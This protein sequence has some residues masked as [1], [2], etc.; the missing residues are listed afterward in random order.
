[1]QAEHAHGL[2]H[3]TRSTRGAHGTIGRL[4]CVHAEHDWRCHES[5]AAAHRRLYPRDGYNRSPYRGL[6]VAWSVGLRRACAARSF[7]STSAILSDYAGAIARWNSHFRGACSE[8][9]DYVIDVHF[10]HDLSGAVA[11][12]C[13]PIQIANPLH[14]A[15]RARASERTH[16]ARVP[17]QT[18]PVGAAQRRARR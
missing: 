1:M 18:P 13:G 11:M 10:Y 7:D 15:E 4:R 9:S 14:S 2:I 16:C 6:P 8:H 5:E 3:H 12:H 17:P